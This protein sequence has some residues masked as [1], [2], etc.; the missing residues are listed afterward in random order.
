MARGW[1]SKSVEQQQDEVR[2]AKE[3]K[4]H[5]TPEQ[6]EAN[7]RKQGLMLSR[8]RILQQISSAASPV[9]LSTLQQALA[10]IEDQISHLP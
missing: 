7:V 4:P 8:S 1:E 10:D 6:K 9:Y 2:S 5:L 3:A